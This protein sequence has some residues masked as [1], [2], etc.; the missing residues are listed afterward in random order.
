ME[1]SRAL[2]AQWRALSKADRKYFEDLAE[3][4]RAEF[5]A[6]HPEFRYASVRKRGKKSAADEENAAGV[7]VVS[8]SP[9]QPDADEAPPLMSF[10]MV[11][12]PPSIAMT[13]SVMSPAPLPDVNQEVQQAL[14]EVRRLFRG[15]T[16]MMTSSSAS[17]MMSSAMSSAMPSAMNP[18]Y[19]GPWDI[20][21]EDYNM[22]QPLS[23]RRLTVPSFM[24]GA[25]YVPIV[26]EAPMQLFPYYVGTTNVSTY[27]A[28]PNVTSY[29]LA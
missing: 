23:N 14:E 29:Y 2:G 22:V 16:A 21:N 24:P 20:T 15:P 9:E 19:A 1:I 11:P 25:S 13:E 26:S 17:P 28:G 3:K 27:Y 7:H 8:K 10:D 18:S 12:H 4:T 5:K 6:A